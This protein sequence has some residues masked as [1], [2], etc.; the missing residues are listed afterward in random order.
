MQ[1]QASRAFA[2]Q[3][4]L[5][6]SPK[7]CSLA[8]HIALEE[9][10]LPYEAVAVDIRAGQN[11]TPAYLKINPA[12]AVP[13]LAV[14]N[15]VV[16]ESHAI[17][18]HIADLAPES[19]LIPRPGTLAR[20]RAHEWMNWISG[21]M[22]VAYR[23]IFRPQAYAGDDPQ[24][25]N[26]VREHAQKKLAKI[27]QEVETRLGEA[28]YAL[29]ARFSAVDAYLFV[30]YTWS[31]DE[32]IEAALPDRPRYAALAERL[33]ARPAVR[34]ALARERAVRPYELPPGFARALGQA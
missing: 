30:F 21:T 11:T 14:G 2:P 7:A 4:T 34:K 24:A 31:F 22:H 17:L 9:S 8:P 20:A 32:R 13:S 16:T 19:E 25:M 23:S 10:G 18:T 5:Y 12:G 6:Y 27:L 29:G 1:D 15:A 28:D 26:S 33:L 3:L